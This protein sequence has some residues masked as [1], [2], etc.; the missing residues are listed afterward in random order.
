M[1]T[2]YNSSKIANWMVIMTLVLLIPVALTGIITAYANA[3]KIE[4][5][6]EDLPMDEKYRLINI[7]NTN[8]SK[9]DSLCL[10]I[11]TLKFEKRIQDLR[12]KRVELPK[13]PIYK[14]TLKLD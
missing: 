10:V 14:D 5:I 8:Q 11:D 12:I 1:K 6:P 2:A 13:K 3:Q 9:I 7:I 4:A